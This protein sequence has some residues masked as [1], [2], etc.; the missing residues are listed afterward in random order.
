MSI[1]L[2]LETILVLFA[3]LASNGWIYSLKFFNLKNEN[4]SENISVRINSSEKDVL[5]P[6]LL[7][8]SNP[9]EISSLETSD[10]Q[11]LSISP[12]ET[13]V[14]QTSSVSSSETAISQYIFDNENENLIELDR[15]EEILGNILNSILPDGNV[16]IVSSNFDID[17]FETY[18]PTDSV[19]IL[20]QET[21][22]QW[23]EIAMDLHDLP[24]NTPANIIQQVKFEELNILYSKDIAE[25]AITQTE[26]RLI[27]E[28]FPSINLFD[29]SINHLILTM[30]SYYH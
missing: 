15:N 28:S 24:Y 19:T 18:T 25:F 26:L 16:D 23:R 14:S 20:N 6:T 5:A 12:S 4:S 11:T 30:M 9:I 8:A 29:P 1:N 27:I 7:I 22:W 17:N 2:V 21:F 3:I 13:A 10:S